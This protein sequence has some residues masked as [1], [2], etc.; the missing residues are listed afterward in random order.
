[1]LYPLHKRKS[2]RWLSACLYT[3][4]LILVI[5][6]WL[7]GG[8]SQVEYLLEDAVYQHASTVSPNIFVIGIDEVT[9]SAL[10]PFDEWSRKGVAEFVRTITADPKYAPAVIGIDIG[11]Y[12]EKDP[13]ADRL[14]VE[15]C[16]T[17][18]NVVV[19][20][21]ASFG[22]TIRYDSMGNAF[23]ATEVITLEKPFPALAAVVDWGHTN[24]NLD[25]DGVVRYALQWFSAGPDRID[26][27]ASKIYKAYTGHMPDIPLNHDHQWRIA[28]SGQPYAYYGLPGVGSSFVRVLRGEYPTQAF[29]GS[30]VLIG[31]YASGMMDD[32]DTPINHEVRMH[33]VEIHANL[34]EAML[35][36]KYIRSLP[37]P[38]ELILC[39]A[40]WS[41]LIFLMQKAMIR[42]SIPLAILLMG[43][44][45]AAAVLLSYRQ[46]FLP[47]L[48]PLMGG[49]FLV[50][51]HLA[52]K[53]VSGWRERRHIIE[54]FSR[55]LPLEV[56]RSIA[57]HGEDALRLGGTKR[58]IGVLFVDIRGFTPLSELLPPEQLV[59]LLNQYLDLT[60]ACIFRH[61]GAVDKFIGDATMA[62]FNAPSELN[63]YVFRA[64]SSALEM[65]ELSEVLNATL[66]ADGIEGIGFGIGINCGEAVVGNIGT[67]FRMEYTAI[68]DT[69]NTAS[70]LEG[71]ARAGEVLITEF[72]YAHIKDRIACHYLGK[73]KLR[74]KRDRVPVWRA[75]HL[76]ASGES[77][78]V[79]MPMD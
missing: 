30:I 25:V 64:V 76:L 35:N 10:G 71:Q 14:L 31:A 67:E 79:E 53:Y 37:L 15:A 66:A 3:L 4:P 12:G 62:L 26:S 43:L 38:F 9:L 40:L 74:G 55:Y 24:F 44:Y 69:V 65:I 8:L 41:A 6:G 22:N 72:V 5:A 17:A 63:D 49:G 7:G 48:P 51:L 47:I 75:E 61:G 45:A 42:F 34:L 21:A 50:V 73:Q 60:T 29:A 46:L 58:E 28:Y 20:G 2:W 13:E 57:E 11:Y 23:T 16:Q 19:A 27:F 56:A 54:G 33:G 52:L 39:A 36:E 77:P 32:Y 1:M 70:R 18:G 78:E 68:G 59:A